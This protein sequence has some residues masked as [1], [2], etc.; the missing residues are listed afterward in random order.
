MKKNL[1]GV[2]AAFLLLNLLSCASTS[3]HNSRNS[4][5]WAGIYNGVIPSAGG[6][7]IDV[8]ITLNADETYT[9]EYQYVGKGDEIFTQS[10]SISWKPDGNTVILASEGEGGF[11]PYYKLGENTLTHLDLEGNIITGELANDYIL[12]KQP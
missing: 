4:L 11:P 2:V 3:S 7:G 1:L 8:T 6:E 5:D 10:G 9:I 12:K